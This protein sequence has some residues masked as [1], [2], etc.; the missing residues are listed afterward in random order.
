MIG[1][2]EMNKGTHNSETREVHAEARPQAAH[3]MR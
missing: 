2:Q 3:P 1:N